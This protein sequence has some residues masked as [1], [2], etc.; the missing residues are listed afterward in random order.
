MRERK[1]SEALRNTDVN[2]Q[3]FLI[4]SLAS[5]TAHRA[6]VPHIITVTITLHRITHRDAITLSVYLQEGV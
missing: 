6:I 1:L 5:I 3:R 2:K 4:S